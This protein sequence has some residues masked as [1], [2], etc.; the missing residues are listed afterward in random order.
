MRSCGCSHL[1]RAR[2]PCAHQF[3][4]FLIPN[5]GKMKVKPHHKPLAA[6]QLL[7]YICIGLLTTACLFSLLI[8]L[9]LPIIK[10][11]YLLKV[12]STSQ[13]QPATSVATEL[14]FG[15]WGVCANSALNEPSF[16]SDTAECF[17]P[18]LGYTVPADIIALTGV[19]TSIVNAVLKS[20]LVILV[21]HVVAAI[22]SLITLASSLFL[23][24]HKLSIL[25]LVFAIITAIVSSVVF[26][27]DVAIVVVAKQQV[28]TLAANGLQFAIGWGNG[29]WLGLVAVILTW[30]AVIV[31]SMRA[32]YCLGVRPDGKFLT[33]Q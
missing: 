32:C 13:G 11:I 16:F 29:P 20:L 4:E 6:Y 31:L 19:S 8:G 28:P 24:S 12:S 5:G 10:Q 17:G 25:S 9:S 3:L 1:P 23:A 2:S 33:S 27:I 26:A 15:V 7:S 22:L 30:A 14:R 18:M 21:L